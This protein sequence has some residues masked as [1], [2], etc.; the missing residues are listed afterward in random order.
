[1]QRLML[2]DETFRGQLQKDPSRGCCISRSREIL[3]KI[4]TSLMKNRCSLSSCHTCFNSLGKCFDK[5]EYH[6]GKNEVLSKH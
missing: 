3:M 4:L 6:K 1:M 2:S 5:K